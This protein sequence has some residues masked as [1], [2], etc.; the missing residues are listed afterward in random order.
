M[1]AATLWAPQTETERLKL[2]RISHRR[3]AKRYAVQAKLAKIVWA[4]AF[5]RA[6]NAV[7]PRT[8]VRIPDVKRM[9]TH[10]HHCGF[11]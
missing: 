10:F 2:K 6:V 8:V 11:D 1:V 7:N 3:E 9:F 5:K 4:E